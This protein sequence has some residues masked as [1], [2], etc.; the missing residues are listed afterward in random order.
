MGRPTS[1]PRVV[2]VRIRMNEEESAMLA[3]CANKLA[4][5]KTNVIVA[6]I[7]KVYADIKRKI[8]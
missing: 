1:S 6:G 2:Q 7:R 8:G 4:T 3:E 5:T